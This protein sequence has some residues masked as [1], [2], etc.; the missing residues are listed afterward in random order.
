[1]SVTIFP[2]GFGNDRRNAP[3]KSSGVVLPQFSSFLL[4][5]VPHMTFL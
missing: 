5:H 4:A 1:M 2:T 3:L